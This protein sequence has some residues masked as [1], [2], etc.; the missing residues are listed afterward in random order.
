MTERKVVIAC[1]RRDVAFLHQINDGLD[2]TGVHRDVVYRGGCAVCGQ[3][4]CCCTVAAG[5]GNVER[6]QI[7]LSARSQVKRFFGVI[8]ERA[9][10]DFFH[11][12]FREIVE[13][14][15][16]GYGI[17]TVIVRLF[18]RTSCGF[19]QAQ[20]ISSLSGRALVDGLLFPHRLVVEPSASLGLS[21]YICGLAADC[22]ILTIFKPSRL[23]LPAPMWL[24]KL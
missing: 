16:V 4:H 13:L 14:T 15:G 3:G 2:V 6:R 23:P 20:T 8:L 24:V 7:K 21:A 22:P 12:L 9:H 18:I 10:D 5:R 1:I 19:P 11:G 17:Q